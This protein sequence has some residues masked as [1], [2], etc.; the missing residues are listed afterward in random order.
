MELQKRVKELR[1]RGLGVAV[2]SYDSREILEAFSRQHGVTFPLLSDKGSEAIKRYGMLNTVVEEAFGPNRDDP[3]VK[4]AVQKYVSPVDP[5]PM[6]K[7]MAFPGTFI[8]DRKGRV[9]SRFFE[10]IM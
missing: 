2:I 8:L 1:D 9:T 10:V 3:A 6:M 5:P 4:A 7:G